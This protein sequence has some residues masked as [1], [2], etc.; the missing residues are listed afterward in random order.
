MPSYKQVR[1]CSLD[2]K[3][4]PAIVRLLNTYARLCGITVQ[5]A[6]E[7]VLQATLPGKIAHLR[8]LVKRKDR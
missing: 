4:S 2:S 8:E 6:A 7:E 1:C 3:R 5:Q